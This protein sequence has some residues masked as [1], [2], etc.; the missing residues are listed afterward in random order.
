[1]NIDLKPYYDKAKAKTDAVQ[2][3]AGELNTA[4][5]DGTDEGQEKAKSLRPSLEAAM[6]EADDANKTYI[7]MRDA[8]AKENGAA[9]N[10]VPAPA[11]QSQAADTKVIS[12]AEFEA[13]DA[14]A[15]MK[16][17]KSGGTVTDSAE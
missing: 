7:T 17:V 8:S 3:I 15:R 16:F 10:F 13:L 1:M 9:S 2:K 4:F 12:R 11:N 6:A 14:A 5:N